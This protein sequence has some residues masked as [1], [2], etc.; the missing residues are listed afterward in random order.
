MP[1]LPTHMH[2][3]N[4]V[5]GIY[6]DLD[7]GKHVPE[8][9][10]GS[11][12]PDIR[13]ITKKNRSVYHFV[14]LDFEKLGDGLRNMQ[15]QYGSWENINGDDL[16]TNTFMA[17]Y[18]SHLILD[19]TWITS[20]FRRYFF[21][22]GIFGDPF[23][24]LVMDRALQLELDRRFWS[25]IATFLHSLNN[26]ETDLDVVFLRGEPVEEWRTWVVSLLDREFSWERL[27]FMGKR[28]SGGDSNHPA[29]KITEDFVS[30]PVEGVEFILNKLP[31]GAVEEFIEES[32]TNMSLILEVLHA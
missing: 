31:S 20:M 3:A 9:I 6:G 10:L 18:A 12:C 8:F 24:A 23:E 16:V 21:G 13:V 22:D 4:E 1:N 27:L 25:E 2:F 19:E 11:T 29:I 7:C 14:D 26:A 28:I 5:V 15:K 30:N 32:R 17:G